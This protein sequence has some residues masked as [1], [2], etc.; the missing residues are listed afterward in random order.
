M[1]ISPATLPKACV[2]G[3]GSSLDAKRVDF[4]AQ[5]RTLAVGSAWEL[6]HLNISLSV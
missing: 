5:T 6:S 3:V 1:I 2:N 4:Q